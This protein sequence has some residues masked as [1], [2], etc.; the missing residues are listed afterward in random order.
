M[1]ENKKGKKTLKVV[2]DASPP[3]ATSAMLR[4]G[5]LINYE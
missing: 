4:S 3:L 5:Y 1:R 2:N